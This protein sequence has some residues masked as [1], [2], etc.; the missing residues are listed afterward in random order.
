MEIEKKIDIDIQKMFFTISSR[1]HGTPNGY[2]SH[3]VQVQE[4]LVSFHFMLSIY[5]YNQKI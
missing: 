2:E 5:I 1:V 4:I 3:G